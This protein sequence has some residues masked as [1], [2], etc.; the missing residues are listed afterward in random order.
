LHKYISTQNLKIYANLCVNYT[1][2]I[3]F[4]EC[5]NLKKGPVNLRPP[6]TVILQATSDNKRKAR[7]IAG[8]RAPSPAHARA[9]SVFFVQL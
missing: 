5:F 1:K 2:K 9:L 3:Y 8:A 6:T 7:T 4:V